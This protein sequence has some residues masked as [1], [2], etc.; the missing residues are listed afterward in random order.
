MQQTTQRDVNVGLLF[1]QYL[2]NGEVNNLKLWEFLCY[3]NEEELG[4][5]QMRFRSRIFKYV[6]NIKR[7][8]STYIKIVYM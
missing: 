7:I 5:R 3:H 4:G 2:V 8:S 1:I 6:R